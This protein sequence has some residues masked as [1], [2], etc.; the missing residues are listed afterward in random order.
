M[1]LSQ[2]RIYLVHET[3]FRFL[4]RAMD[5]NINTLPQVLYSCLAL[6]NYLELYK[7]K[8]SKQSL[9]LTLN[10]EKRVEPATSNLSFNRV[11]NEKKATDVHNTLTLSFEYTYTGD[12]FQ[13]FSQ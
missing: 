4:Q 13:D 1:L 11:L 6:H 10:L 9:A 8:I 2:L 5:I 12:M 7:E 3:R